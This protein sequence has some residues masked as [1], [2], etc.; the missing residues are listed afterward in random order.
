MRAAISASLVMVSLLGVARGGGFA[1]EAP[2]ELVGP[3]TQELIFEA[4][5]EWQDRMVAYEPRLDVVAALKDVADFVQIEVY[6]GSW[7]SDSAVQIPAFI[8]VLN[9]VNSPQIQATYMGV[10]EAQEAR[11]AYIAG[12]EIE[13]IPTFIILVN[14]LE[15]GRIVEKPAVSIEEDLLALIRL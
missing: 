1:Q 12:K 4:L 3:L 10:P 7:C 14:G 11:G 5:P 8:Q 6:L 9:L 15:K 2:P 13:K